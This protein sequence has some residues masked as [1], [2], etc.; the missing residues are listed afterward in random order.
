MCNVVFKETLNM[1]DYKMT[2]NTNMDLVCEDHDGCELLPLYCMDCDCPLCSYC[3]T[4][5]HVGHTFQYVS[6]VVE[7]QNSV[8]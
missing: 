7:T 2:G 1:A 8:L 3:I 4:R 5:N 6:E